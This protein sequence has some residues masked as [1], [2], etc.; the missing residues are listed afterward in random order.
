MVTKILVCCHKND[1]IISQDPYFPIQV[2]KSISSVDLGIQGDDTGD[3]ISHKNANYCELTGLYWAWKNLKGVDVIGLCHYRRYFDFHRQCQF[4]IPQTEFGTES[5][6]KLNLS[7]TDEYIERVLKGK[8]VIPSP[9]HSPQTLMQS[10][11]ESHVSDDFRIMEHVVKESSVEAGNAFDDIIKNGNKLSRYNMFIMNWDHFNEYCNWLFQIL[12]EIE[13]RT[14][15]SNYNCIQQRVYGY[16]AE[17]LFNV[18]IKLTNADTI[19]L[20]VIFITDSPRKKRNVLLWTI[21][22]LV[23]D[24]VNLINKQARSLNKG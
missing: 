7:L 12:A 11:C 10:Y 9:L 14:D 8:I 17:R 3:N 20:P 2:G 13:R 1:I 5:F 21:R 6:N 22:D 24:S 4:G 18:W 15:I 23:W 19:K 16:M